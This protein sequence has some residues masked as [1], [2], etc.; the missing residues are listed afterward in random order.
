M[1]RQNRLDVVVSSDEI[2]A[3]ARVVECSADADI[4]SDL[5]QCGYRPKTVASHVQRWRRGGRGGVC[6]GGLSRVITQ[7][8]SLF[9]GQDR[10]AAAIASKMVR[11][12]A[13]TAALS[14]PV[15]TSMA[16]TE[17]DIQAEPHLGAAH[18][19]CRPAHVRTVTSCQGRDARAWKAAAAVLPMV[20]PAA[21]GKRRVTGVPLAAKTLDTPGRAAPLVDDRT[22]TDRSSSASRHGRPT[23]SG[24]VGWRQLSSPTSDCNWESVL[25]RA[26]RKRIQDT[27]TAPTPSQFRTSS[28]ASGCKKN[29]RS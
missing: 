27:R 21:R 9:G 2:D 17:N 16:S 23:T 22:S 7:L 3:L 18:P 26:T 19:A 29:V 6:Q 11:A 4:P 15:E 1:I 24:I 25:C 28:G 10:W 14:C 8:G 5:A 13:A 12:T 20:S